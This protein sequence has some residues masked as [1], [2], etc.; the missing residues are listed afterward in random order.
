ML[1]LKSARTAQRFPPRAVFRLVLGPL[2]I[3]G[4][5]GFE[6]AGHGTTP[7]VL[8]VYLTFVA[9]QGTVLLWSRWRLQ[10]ARRRLAAAFARSAQLARRR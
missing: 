10:R 6:F 1:P 3:A 8:A 9:A 5:A 2:V 4:L 7:T